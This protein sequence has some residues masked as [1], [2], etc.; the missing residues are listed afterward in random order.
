MQ[1]GELEDEVI[2]RDLRPLLHE[3]I[4]R[5]PERYR[6]P[7][8]L[9]YLEGK[10]SEQAASFL[11]LPK[12]TVQ[13]RLS[14]ARERLRQRLIRSGL[15]LTGGVLTALLVENV[16]QAVV[17]VTLA[18]STLKAASLFASGAIT[19]GGIPASVLAHAE[20]MLR[21]AFVAKLKLATAILMGVTAVGVGTGVVLYGVRPSVGGDR[22]TDSQPLP[23]STSKENPQ[24]LPRTSDQMAEDRNKLQGVWVV[25][26]TEQHGRSVDTLN[27][28][29][30][31]FA[32][33][34]FTFRAGR[35]EVSGIIPSGQMEGNFTLESASPK[36]IDLNSQQWHFAGI[37]SVDDTTL[38]MCIG[39]GNSRERPADF[40]TKAN[41]NQLLLILR[42]E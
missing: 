18:A 19:A 26:E 36:Q 17:P 3:E 20:G 5:L 13:S 27:N 41:G 30:V 14:R 35:G 12:G 11:G 28:R 4:G 29:R 1:Y 39:K 21:A 25:A 33:N 6:L 34:R 42:R 32:G 8:V 37:Y 7:L 16:A 15:A 23:A 22:V 9:C 2:W 24:V 31:V 40:T 38:K 10:T